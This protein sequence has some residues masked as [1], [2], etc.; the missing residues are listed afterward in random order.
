MASSMPR[1]AARDRSAR[2]STANP[3]RVRRSWHHAPPRCPGARRCHSMTTQPT[4]RA[5]SSKRA[6][7]SSPYSLPSMSNLQD[8][9][10]L[11]PDGLEEV[12]LRDLE[13]VA[14][15][16]LERGVLDHSRPEAVVLEPRGGGRARRCRGANQR[17]AVGIVIHPHVPVVAVAVGRVRFVGQHAGA[18]IRRAPVKA[19]VADVRSEIDDPPHV[20][21]RQPGVV[22]A[23]AEHFVGRLPVVAR[24][25][26]DRQ[27]RA[28][29]QPAA[30][31]AP[32]LPG[33]S[34]RDSARG[35]ER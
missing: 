7:C 13:H 32:P 19:R 4:R 16:V 18:R 17:D 34:R 15:S 35:R 31:G 5:R 28:A 14:A 23:L 3:R 6:S 30:Q 8:V 9:D 22:G 25:G 24:G 26:P 2:S 11:G 27:Q 29:P 33:G 20:V 10:R 12:D 1:S 21:G